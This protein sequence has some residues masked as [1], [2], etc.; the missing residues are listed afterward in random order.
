MSGIFTNLANLKPYLVNPAMLKKVFVLFLLPS[1]I[2]LSVAS[3]PEQSLFTYRAKQTRWVDS[4]FN[5]MTPDER[6]GQLF[7]TAAY[8]NQ[9]EKHHKEI[10]EL[11]RNYNI[12]GL[13]F[14]QGG[15][16]RQAQLTNRYQS[17]AKVPLLIGMDAEWGLG[18]RLDSTISYPRQ[19]TLGAIT[20]NDY[21]YQ[22]GAEIA[23]QCK[24]LGVHINFAP[25][26]D[27]NSNPNNPVIGV[28]SFGE[29]KENVAAKAIAYARGL[30]HNGVM[31]N[32]KH[33]PG[34]GDT[35]TDSHM[36]LPVI[37][38]ARKRMS[39]VEL[40]PFKKLFA[41]SLMSVMVGHMHVPIYDNT[42]NRATTLSEAIVT[43]LLKKEL[44]FKGLVFTDALN[45][46]GVTQ[47]YKPA[48]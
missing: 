18:M 15:P 21:V 38:H 42:K 19:M 28:R 47:F 13:I 7:M 25:V 46:K 44:G 30:Q 22:M 3:D 43:D 26:V 17:V 20:D 1:V 4:V 33:F 41:D 8:S 12:G 37:A 23:R 32:A 34:H 48:M 35:D 16:V 2:L 31:A 6:L 29:D 40:Y 27:I 36:A 5:S 24:R 9:N 45:M 10:E 14:F 39:E 11:I